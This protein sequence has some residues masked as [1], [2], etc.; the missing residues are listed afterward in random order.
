M[1]FLA[2]NAN[3]CQH[4]VAVHKNTEQQE[5]LAGENFGEFSDSLPLNS[6]K[7]Y[8]PIAHSMLI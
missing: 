2:K 4:C 1:L 3:F 7:F 6:P 5:T 8:P